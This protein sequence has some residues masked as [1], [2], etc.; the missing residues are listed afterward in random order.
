MLLPSGIWTDQA[1]KYP[2]HRSYSSRN[3]IQTPHE[4][5][6]QGE[7]DIS[8][9]RRQAT[10]TTSDD[11]DSDMTIEGKDDTISSGVYRTM[12]LVPLI[13][14]PVWDQV[15]AHIKMSPRSP[16]VLQG[17]CNEAHF[18]RSYLSKTMSLIISE[19]SQERAVL[20]CLDVIIANDTMENVRAAFIDL[21][22]PSLM[23][24]ELASIQLLD[25]IKKL[26]TRNFRE[27]LTLPSRT[28]T[29]IWR[30]LASRTSS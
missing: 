3:P 2:H 8:K 5:E 17:L 23:L 16:E 26:I 25:R 30:L 7:S 10:F 19:S 11:S 9:E 13:V 4:Q 21:L 27:Y 22:Y 28:R 18:V 15:K 24:V 1:F 29:E 14:S 6:D 12:N 20:F